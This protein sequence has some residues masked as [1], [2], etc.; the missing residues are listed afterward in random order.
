MGLSEL[1]EALLERMG[2]I[3]FLENRPFSYLDFIPKFEVNGTEY[4]VRYGTLRNQFSKLRRKGEI[5]LEFR[6]KQAFYTIMGQKFG[7]QKL[8]TSNPV[9][10]SRISHDPISKLI[11]SLPFGENALHDIHL[12]FKVKGIWNLLSTNSAL[13]IGAF[14]KDLRLPTL[15]IEDL[16][17]KVTIHR[18]NTVSVVVGC[19]YAPIAIDC[20]GIIYLSNALTRVEERLSRLAERCSSEG[21][22]DSKTLIIPEH[23]CWTVSLWHFGIDSITEYTGERFCVSWEVGQDALIRAYTKDMKELGTRIRLERQ[24]YPGKTFEAAVAEKLGVVGDYLL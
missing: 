19:S 7:K 4:S 14:N 12:R 20:T 8:M 23:S 24:E 6:T 16:Q 18:S 10:V 22:E 5:E 21:T 9:G 17:I 11:T 2:N 3:V 13:R 1:G 15:K